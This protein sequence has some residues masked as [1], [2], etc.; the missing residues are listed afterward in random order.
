MDK[1]SQILAQLNPSTSD[2]MLTYTNEPPAAHFNRACKQAMKDLLNHVDN[3]WL[4]THYRRRGGK[5]KGHPVGVAI[6]FFID[7]QLYAGASAC[8]LAAQAPSRQ[9]RREAQE[10][11]RIA[12]RAIGVHPT[13]QFAI[14]AAMD[15]LQPDTAGTDT[16]L[17]H[18][19]RWKAIK[20]A[21]PLD[22]ELAAAVSRM[23]YSHYVSAL[24][25]PST[26]NVKTQNIVARAAR[27]PELPEGF[28]NWLHARNDDGTRRV[29]YRVIGA[30]ASSI[31]SAIHEKAKLDVTEAAKIFADIAAEAAPVKT[32]A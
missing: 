3:R 11:A 25:N 21:R 24:L 1:L 26:R 8:R 9:A 4:F 22:A 19:G 13:M 12:M 16:W 7:G 31:S 20:S 29:P 6:A 27:R 14:L 5:S 30:I 15:T 18:V 23:V 28:Q 17:R 10:Q 32:G 2:T